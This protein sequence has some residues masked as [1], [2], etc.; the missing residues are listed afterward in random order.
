MNLDKF[1]KKEFI[2][3][4]DLGFGK[5]KI[6]V[7]HGGQGSPLLLIHGNPMN[8]LTWHKIVPGLIKKHYIVLVDIRGYGDSIGPKNGGKNHI[9]YSFRAMGRD[10]EFIINKLGYKTF[11]VAGHD[12]G[13]RITHRMCLDFKKKIS[14]AAVIDILPNRH[15][16]KNVNKDWAKAYWHW[17]FMI[18][19]Y[20]FP[21]KLM[22]SV[23]ASYFMK[24]KL[25]KL[26][27]DFSF[28]K[29]TFDDYVRCFNWKTICASC[30]DY[31]ASPTCDLDLDEEDFVANNKIECPLLVL[32]GDKSH[33]EIT[34]GNVLKT[35]K[36]YCNNSV[37]GSKIDAGHYVQEENPV[38]TLVWFSKFFD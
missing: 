24:K 8:Q 27:I 10:F 23:P 4:P 14:K 3:I 7:R 20:D 12:R 37:L 26:N 19:P 15:L 38:D 11:N 34:D 18:Q 6:F 1:L 31:R 22:S 9:N 36:N 35:W 29:D 30:E 25:S 33:T 28:C 16:W 21:E 13:A 5:S 32:W 17:V 2:E